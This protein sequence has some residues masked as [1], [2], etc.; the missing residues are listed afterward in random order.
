MATT[1][2][3]SGLTD[4]GDGT[5]GRVPHD[6]D[7]T[8]DRD[9]VGGVGGPGGADHGPDGPSP[10]RRRPGGARGRGQ[11]PGGRDGSGAARETDPESAARAI[12]LRQLTGAAKSRKQLEDKLRAREIPEPAAR[13]VLD[14]FEELQL[15]DD[16][17]FAQAWV[18]SRSQ[19]KGLARGALRREL[20]DKGIDPELADAALEQLGADD[21]AHA[22]R[23]LAERRLRS[24]APGTDRDRAVRRVVGMLA[25]KG[26]P[27]GLAFRAASEAWEARMGDA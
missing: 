17:A 6:P 23:L 9:R 24:V 4:A 5:A 15:V 10:D 11:R 20:R 16:A 12:V 21:E 1:P 18:R 14:R 2:D 13:S 8:V 7:G 22:A 26:Y 3:W 19:S 25:R 27:P